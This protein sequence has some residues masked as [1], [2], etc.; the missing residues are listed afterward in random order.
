MKYGFLHQT[1]AHFILP[2]FGD[3]GSDPSPSLKALILRLWGCFPSFLLSNSPLKVS[4]ISPLSA[5]LLWEGEVCE[6]SS[7]WDTGLSARSA[8]LAQNH[9]W[10]WGAGLGGMEAESGGTHQQPQQNSVSTVLCWCE[11]NINIAQRAI[12]KNSS[13]YYTLA[14]RMAKWR[15]DLLFR[16]GRN[17][18]ATQELENQLQKHLMFR[19]T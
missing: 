5:H 7:A 10:E 3:R 1:P 14:L 15:D 19:S 18:I 11:W 4:P 8:S 12:F 17:L 9:R 2:C 6:L 16:P 13:K